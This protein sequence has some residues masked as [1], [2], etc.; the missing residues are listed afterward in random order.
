MRAL[1]ASTL[2]VLPLLSAAA[3]A[4]PEN[5]RA[6]LT[7]HCTKCHSGEKPKGKLDLDALAADFS[8]DADRR[9]W[10]IVAERV[11][12]GTMPPKSAAA[13]GGRRRAGADRLD[14]RPGRG[15]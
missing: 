15:C 5:V 9:R 13:A 6:F 8:V 14:R 3:A 11:K 2:L 10:Q 7:T 1:L 4:P 12:A